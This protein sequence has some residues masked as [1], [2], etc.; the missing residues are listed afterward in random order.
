MEDNIVATDEKPQTGQ[1]SEKIRRWIFR[2]F[3]RK[4]LRFT[5]VASLLIF[6]LYMAA[7]IPDL[8]FSDRVLFALLRLLR[9]VSLV[10]CA[11]SL[12]ALGSSVHQMV[13]NPSLRHFFGLCLSFGISLLS[14]GLTMLDSLIIAATAGNA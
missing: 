7:S 4:G 11:F 2:G 12:F 3:L 6:A 14:A 1:E 13:Y 10:T 8:G 5:F 9:Y